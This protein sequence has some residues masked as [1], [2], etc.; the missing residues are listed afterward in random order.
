MQI[1]LAAIFLMAGVMK[2]VMPAE[3]LTKDTALSA[4]FLR[5]IAACEVLGALGLLLPGITGIRPQLTPLAAAG[6]LVIMSG[7]VI[8]TLV[9]S[10]DAVLAVWPFAVGVMCAAVL[11]GRTRIVRHG[12]PMPPQPRMSYQGYGRETSG[13]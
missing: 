1:A 9:E 4:E 8:V 6:L 3:D 13:R 5:F 2:L 7:A 12:A 10:D 11:Y